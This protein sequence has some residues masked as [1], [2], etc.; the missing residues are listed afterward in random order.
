MGRELSCLCDG[1]PW[2][3]CW[4]EDCPRIIELFNRAAKEEELEIER[5][6]A[7]LDVALLV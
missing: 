4:E 6:L 7:K 1:P 2:L 5:A 3:G